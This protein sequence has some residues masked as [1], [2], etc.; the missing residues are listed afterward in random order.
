M[1]D[2]VKLSS[3]DIEDAKVTDF[4]KDAEATIA[5]ETNRSMDYTDCSQAETAAIKNL[6]AMR[7]QGYRSV[8]SVLVDSLLF[9]EFSQGR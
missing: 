5:E 3:T 4:V 8:P 2:R 7:A 6:A 9:L 1:R